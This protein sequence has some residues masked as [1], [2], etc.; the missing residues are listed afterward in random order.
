M[1]PL[2]LDGIRVIDFTQVML[3]PCCTQTLADYGADVIKIEKASIGD[4]S[5][6]S[7]GSDPDEL[8]NPVFCSLNRNKKSLALDLKQDAVLN[9][10]LDLIKHADVVVNNFRPGVMERM[11]LG[12][13]TLKALNPRLIFAVGTGFGLEGPYRHKGGQDILAQALTGLMKRKSDEAHPTS[14]YA[15]P[16]AD[17]AAGM[18]LAQG[19]LLALLHRAK[20]GEGQQVSVSLYSSMLALQMQEGAAWMMREK[21]LNWGAFPL[22]GCFATTDGEIVMVG[23]FKLNPLRDICAALEI[24]D[25]SVKPDFADFDRQM[26]NRSALQAIFHDRFAQNSSA[27]WLKRLE[28]VDILCAP[29]RTLAEALDDEQ[30]RINGMVLEAGETPAGPVRLVGSPI[31]LSAAPVA[32]R[33]APPGLG[34]HNA[35]FFPSMPEALRGDAA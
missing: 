22:T 12:Y 23:A 10:I 17:Y 24:E 26:S 16:L 29:V 1:T 11:G 13:E 31:A 14:I 6:W 28:D 33:I 7:L 34:Q 32:V 25:L 4:L 19:I 5:R 21:K 15:T 18:H 30:T 3:G 20:T 8:N 2:P 35:E 9:G 27:H